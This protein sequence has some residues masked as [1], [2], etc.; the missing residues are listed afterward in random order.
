LSE[1][2]NKLYVTMNCKQRVAMMGKSGESAI[3]MNAKLA[4]GATISFYNPINKTI[5][6]LFS[7]S[8]F[9]LYLKFE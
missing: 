4:K 3:K 6:A 1:N 9:F 5:H 7:L 2:K 8:I